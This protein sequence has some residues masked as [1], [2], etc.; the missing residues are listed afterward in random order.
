M[1]PAMLCVAI[2]RAAWQSRQ[3]APSP[4]SEFRMPLCTATALRCAGCAGQADRSQPAPCARSLAERTPPRL[5]CCGQDCPAESPTQ[6]ALQ[7]GHGP[8][9]RALGHLGARGQPGRGP[10]GLGQSAGSRVEGALVCQLSWQPMPLVEGGLQRS[11]R[12]GSC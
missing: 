6:R 10:P 2:D 1:Q 8:L 4:T 11:W 3:S 9:A 7:R 12:Q 5:A